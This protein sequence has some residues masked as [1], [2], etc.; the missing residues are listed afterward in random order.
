MTPQRC[1][2]VGAGLSGLV[3]ARALQAAGL[4]TLILEKSR[5]VGGRMAT[6]RFQG[7]VFDHGAQFFTVRSPWFQEQVAAWLELG[8]VKRWSLGFPSA[9]REARPDGHPRYRG[10]PGMTAVAKHFA[11]DLE[12]RLQTQ[13]Q[14]VEP[15]EGSW[16]AR[17]A[18]G[19]FFIADALVLTAPV[20]QSLGLI[21]AG[22]WELPAAV[23]APLLEILYDPCLAVLVL[24]DRPAHLPEPGA[25]QFS[26]GPLRWVADNQQKGISPGAAGLTLHAAAGYSRD[27]W[28]APDAQ[29][30]G[31]LTDVILPWLS[32][33]VRAFQV[34][35]WRYS[36]PVQVYAGRSLVVPGPPPLV[37]AGDAFGGPK[38]EGAALSGAHAAH[39]LLALFGQAAGGGPNSPIR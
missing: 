1:L 25:I 10:H 33:N 28:D 23:H 18:D 12:I 35:R 7:G 27:R 6:R 9:S 38:V 21:A 15:R 32:G 26:D 24:L 34:Q 14:A 17:T 2:V 16:H 8:I 5:G 4:S 30:V 22:G 11:R 37:F 36:Q 29:V 19:E 31:E 3:A 39:Q 20:P 13:V